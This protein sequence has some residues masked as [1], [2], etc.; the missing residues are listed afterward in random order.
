MP[1]QNKTDSKKPSVS[2][3]VYSIVVPTHKH[4]DQR[5]AECP[6]KHCAILA[7]F[8]ICASESGTGSTTRIPAR[9]T[10]H[11]TDA[12]ARSFESSVVVVA[13]ADSEGHDSRDG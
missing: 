4:P 10:N 7:P 9:A 1:P 3:V 12:G 2:L 13:A 6:N 5:V 8:E 11:Y